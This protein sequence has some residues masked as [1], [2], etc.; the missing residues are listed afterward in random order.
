[1]FS[2]RKE[3]LR[4]VTVP[5]EVF[6]TW[7][8]APIRGSFVLASMILPSNIW[9]RWAWAAFTNRRLAKKLQ[10]IILLTVRFT[11]WEIKLDN[12]QSIV[13]IVSC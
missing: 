2:N 9:S 11:G 3:P 1:M 10:K 13:Q 12:K 8:A 7:M 6:S 4:S 5:R